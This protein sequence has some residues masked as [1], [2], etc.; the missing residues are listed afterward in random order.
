MKCRLLLAAAGLAMATPTFAAVGDTVWVEGT[1]DCAVFCAQTLRSQPRRFCSLC[2]R[3]A[4]RADAIGGRSTK[5]P[6]PHLALTI[7]PR[8]TSRP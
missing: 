8:A 3:E 4:A 7:F 5:L 2:W 6:H 1:F